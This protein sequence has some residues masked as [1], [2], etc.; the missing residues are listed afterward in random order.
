MPGTAPTPDASRPA[1]PLADPA[2]LPPLDLSRR[3][4]PGREV[5]A[6]AVTMHVRETPG[7]AARAVYVHGLSGSATNWTDL[8][9]LL[10][11]RASGTS[12]DLPGFGKSP[13]LDPRVWTP[14]ANAEVL[15]RFL[16]A[17]GDE[18]VHLLGN[19]LGG[20]VCVL[21]AARHPDLVRTLTLVSPAVPDRRPDPRRLSDPRLA[22][23]MVPGA[24]GRRARAA[25]A[26][27]GP[28]ERAEQVLALCF[29]DP[30][31]APEHRIAE[32]ADEIARRGAVPW[33]GEAVN[34]AA[35]AMF[36]SWLRFGQASLWTAVRAVT[37]P[38]LVVW[39]D[40]DRL[41]APRHAARTVRALRN[42]RL[43]ML[44]GVGHIAQME[45][46]DV[47]AC[48]VAGMWDAVESGEW[49][50]DGAHDGKMRAAARVDHVES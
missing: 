14:H 43:L 42:G 33:A 39:G 38:T 20:S 19:S 34:G 41:V 11:S 30:S 46:P 44:P 10:A 47:V 6:G 28:R 31:R 24:P 48:A 18:P 25:L 7:A 37:V 16:R 22:L 40:R 13:P 35:F 2:T 23:A 27:M 45:V 26:A 3:P 36:A 32:A 21:L 12:V 50:G 1:P 8:A 9:G 5:T 29:G 17:S 4:W 49:A 15:A